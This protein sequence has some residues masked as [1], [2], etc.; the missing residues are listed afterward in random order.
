V[1]LRQVREQPNA[2]IRGRAREKVV[3][4]AALQ[5]F[6]PESIRRVLSPVFPS[7]VVDE[8]A[9]RAWTRGVND[10]AERLDVE[11]LRLQIDTVR[12]E[13]QIG[14]AGGCGGSDDES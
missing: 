10:H 5:N 7:A 6:R 1:T 4:N 9:G 14:T 2:A 11:C 8:H 13:R 12:A 3:T